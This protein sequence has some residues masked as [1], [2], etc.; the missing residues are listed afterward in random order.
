MLDGCDATPLLRLFARRRLARLAVLDAALAQEQQLL[1]LVRRAARTRFGREHD[2]A[3]IHSVADF[4]ARVPLR[5]Y[6]AFWREYWQPA[7][8][9]LENVS[10]P[11][12]IPMF[13]LSS[14]TTTGTTKYIPCTGAMLRA[15]TR[16]GLDLL[17]HHIHH[18]PQSRVLS[19]RTLMLGG[20]SALVPLAAGV[21][22]GDL[23]GIT[24]A[25]IPWW[26]RRFQF[27]PLDVALIEDWEDKV[28]RIAA[29]VVENPGH[30]RALTGM[31]PWLMILFHHQAALMGL[32]LPRATHLF[33]NLDLLVHGGVNFA[34]YQRAFEAFLEGSQ[35]ELR[36]VYPASEGFVALA[37][38]GP[39]DGL[40]LL[41]DNGLFFE[42]V[43]VDELD[44]AEPTRHW[45]GTIETGVNYALVLSSCAGLFA[46]VLGD[47]IRVV[48]RTPPR[49]VVTGR[50]SYTLSA[51]G[52]HLIGEEI[53][54]AVATAA[55]ATATTVADW[56]VGALYPDT[57]HHRGGHL[58]IVEFAGTTPEPTICAQFASTLDATLAEYNDDYRTHRDHD[59][60]LAAPRLHPA[61]AGSFAAWMKHR[62]R[63]GGQNKVPRVINDRALFDD[64]GAFVGVERD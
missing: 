8:P 53:E 48:S 36:E 42:F 45:L 43:P 3:G 13:A 14:G 54:R 24:A 37:D 16:A 10:W 17:C 5:R 41:V 25:R 9:V 38:E 19:G 31:P 30:I 50:T 58:Y 56:A 44:Q 46:Y 26:S 61:P 2:F 55:A 34:P 35:A 32:D 63:L 22:A 18:R 4:Q 33:P 20:S 47:T 59:F 51:F 6:E 15:N 12:R 64:L 57:D 28:A 27:P 23:S 21:V 40:R 52:E 29:M 39:D 7:F 60:G 49:V 62:G 1:E 11:G